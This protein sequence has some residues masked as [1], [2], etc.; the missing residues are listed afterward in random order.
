MVKEFHP[1]THEVL[2]ILIDAGRTMHQESC[3]GTRLDEAFAVTKLITKPIAGSNSRVGIWI[4]DETG[5]VRAFEPALPD[6][7]LIA[8]QELLLEFETRNLLEGP[9]TPVQ[10]LRVSLRK[11]P[12]FLYGERV[13]VFLWLLKLRIREKQSNRQAPRALR[14]YSNRRSTRDAD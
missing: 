8:L 9:A 14:R 3:I 6:Q 7:Q 4:Y 11:A 13:V 5:I 12:D 1:E 10:P 2:Q